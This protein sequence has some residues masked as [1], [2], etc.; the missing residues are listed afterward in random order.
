MRAEDELSSFLEAVVH[1]CHRH[2]LGPVQGFIP[3]YFGGSTRLTR[4]KR[5]SLP[6]VGAWASRDAENAVDGKLSR[7]QRGYLLRGQGII[8]VDFWTKRMYCCGFC[9][10]SGFPT[11]VLA[12]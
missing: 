5:I 6:S 12:V 4:G 8:A 3:N 9:A 7:C 10:V 11:R 2:R 1:C